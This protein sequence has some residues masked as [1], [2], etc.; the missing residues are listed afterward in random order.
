MLLSEGRKVAPVI[1]RV[2][3]NDLI[4]VNPKPE[5]H[6]IGRFEWWLEGDY[7]KIH[8][9]DGAEQELVFSGWGMSLAEI[10]EAEIEAVMLYQEALISTS[11]S[12]EGLNLLINKLCAMTFVDCL[13]LLKSFFND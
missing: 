6:Q 5:S 2:P 1:V 7:L 8:S 11:A 13:A 12:P 10:S 4:I 9:L 3:L